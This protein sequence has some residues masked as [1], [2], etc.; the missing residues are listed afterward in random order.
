MVSNSGLP[1]KDPAEELKHKL[2][3][4]QM[5]EAVKRKGLFVIKPSPLHLMLDAFY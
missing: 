3:Y 4:E 5:V 1:S 2:E